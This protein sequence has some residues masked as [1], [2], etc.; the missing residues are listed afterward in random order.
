ML[1]QCYRESCMLRSNGYAEVK[2]GSL[3]DGTLNPQPPAV[4]LHD[5]PGNRETQTGAASFT[6]TRGIYAVEAFENSFLLHLRDPDA[7]IGDGDCHAAIGGRGRHIDFS[8]GRRILQRITEEI[9]QYLLQAIRIATHGRQV[10]R[11]VDAEGELPG[12]GL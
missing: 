1:I 4:R 3:A 5:V 8:S 7:G 9:L 2:T 12:H 6:R 11:Q 10:F